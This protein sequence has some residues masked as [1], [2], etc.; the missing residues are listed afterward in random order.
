MSELTGRTLLNRYFLRAHV[1]S[2]GMAD[3]YQAWDGIRSAQMAVKVLRRD[4][5]R[6]PRFLQLFRKEADL[7]RTLNHPHIVRLY[8][9]EQ[10]G[11]TL[12]LVMD[13]VEGMDLRQA[14]TRHRKPYSTKETGRILKPVCSA[15]NYAHQSQIYHCDIKPANILLHNDGRVLLTDFGIARVAG[16]KMGAGTPPYMAPEQFTGDVVDGR[17]DVYALGVTLFE[18]LTG[19]YLPFDGNGPQTVGSTAKTRIEWEHLNMAVPP[20]RCFNPALSAAVEAV[21]LTTMNKK[22]EQRYT[23]LLALYDAF[24]IAST[25]RTRLDTE[26]RETAFY[27][28]PPARPVPARPPAHPPVAASSSI[29]GPHLLARSGNMA[30]AV[31]AI[32]WGELRI[33]R[34]SSNHVCLGERSVSRQH[35]AIIRDQRNVYI[36]DLG[37]RLGTY[38]NGYPIN[39]VAMLRVGDIIRIGHYQEFEYRE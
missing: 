23:T 24:E 27:P 32:P 19:G 6:N 5:I 38:V 31:I 18:M 11:D 20:V 10:D 34:S 29:D 17:T 36:K 37:S 35:A 3:V 2:G 39:G 9:F 16:D 21:L 7:L 33:G 30:G 4:L 28:S 22:K 15:L 1:G 14:I 12:F 25:A 13:W 8:D 26:L